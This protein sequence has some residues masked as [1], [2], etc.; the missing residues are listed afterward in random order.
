MLGET[1]KSAKSVIEAFQGVNI[2]ILVQQF[3]K[4]ADATDIRALVIGEKVV[5]AMQAL[6]RARA[7]SAPTC[8]AAARAK[9]CA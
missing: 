2:N 9:W 6:R 8:I 3:V 5:A 7:S 4:E 1:V